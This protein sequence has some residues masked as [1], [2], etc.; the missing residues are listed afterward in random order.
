MVTAQDFPGGLG[1][2]EQAHGQF[3]AGIAAAGDQHVRMLR[4]PKVGRKGVA[5]AQGVVQTAQR[6]ETGAGKICRNGFGHR[7][8]RNQEMVV[9]RYFAAG[10]ERIRIEM[11]GG[12]GQ[13]NVNHVGRQFFRQRGL[14]EPLVHPAP[15][16]IG[17]G[18]QHGGD[19]AGIDQRD[20]A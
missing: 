11:D 13:G 10:H 5:N 18:G 2:I 4:F 20:P 19:R 3:Q 7:A 8:C 1:A 17:Q 6:V 9:A 14:N 15:G 16:D 12:D